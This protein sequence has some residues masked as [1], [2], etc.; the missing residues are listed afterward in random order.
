MPSF[1][2]EKARSP[3]WF[4]SDLY[5]LDVFCV[6]SRFELRRRTCDPSPEGMLAHRFCSFQI[7]IDR[8][9]FATSHVKT[10][11]ENC[12]NSSVVSDSP[13]IL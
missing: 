11:D 2:W 3:T 12:T 6:H 1:A 7:C 8:V 10:R 4:I 9:F 5:G 13:L